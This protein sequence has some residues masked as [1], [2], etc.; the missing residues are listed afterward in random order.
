MRY[1]FTLF[2]LFLVGCSSCKTT[3]EYKKV[4]PTTDSISIAPQ[5]DSLQTSE[6]SASQAQA[7]MSS[8]TEAYEDRQVRAITTTTPIKKHHAVNHL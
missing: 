5:L 4:E 3:H 7:S 6:W 2:I 1:L 8:D